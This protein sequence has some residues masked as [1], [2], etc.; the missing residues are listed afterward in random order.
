MKLIVIIPAYNEERTIGSVIKSIPEVNGRISKTEVIVVDDGSKDKTKEIAEKNGALVLSHRV[1]LG[2]GAAL[3]TGCDAAIMK[4]ADI[5]VILDSDGQHDPSEIPPLLE[6][7]KENDIVFSR[8]IKRE[9]MPLFAK[10]GNFGLKF[11]TRLLFNVNVNDPQSGFRA[12]T[13]ECY[14]KI[15]WN[16]TGYSVENEIIARVGINKLK[17]SEILIKT[18][19]KDKYKGTTLL[20]GFKILVDMIILRLTLRK[21]YQ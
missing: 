1:N 3:K 8:R 10:I 18:I 4:N 19:Y 12:F 21:W 20:D 13:K 7:L 16:T 17:Y 15:R 11:F 9:N 6:K 14:E 5:I 2:K